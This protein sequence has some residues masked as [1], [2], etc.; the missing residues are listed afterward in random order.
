[1]DRLVIRCEGCG[2]FNRLAAERQGT[3]SCGRCHGRLS[4]VGAA[5]AVDGEGLERSIVASPVPILVDFWAPWC[6]PCKTMAPIVDQ[7]ARGHFGR[8]I[9]LKLD[10]EAHPDA[11]GRHAIRGIPTFAVFRDG[12]EVGRLS[13][14]M[15]LRS[16]EALVEPVLRDATHAAP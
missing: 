3:P 4:L 5:Q 6:G 15:P 1:M 11:A 10:T 8:L 13:G 2:A 12:H 16:L 7:L 14:A 9:V